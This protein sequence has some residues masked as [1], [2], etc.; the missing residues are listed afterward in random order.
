MAGRTSITYKN[1]DLFSLIQG[2]V[3]IP[4]QNRPWK[5]GAEKARLRRS[6]G[7]RIES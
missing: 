4:H 5:N 1:N 2:I 3:L 7:G 6:G